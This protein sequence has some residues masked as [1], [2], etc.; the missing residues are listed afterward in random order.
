MR[1][2]V[3]IQTCFW[4]SSIGRVV[5]KQINNEVNK[6]NDAKNK[7]ENK[8]SSAVNNFG[9][10]TCMLYFMQTVFVL[11]SQPKKEKDKNSYSIGHKLF[12]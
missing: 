9:D 4:L 5:L 7:I 12:K 11:D 10:A 8:V 2:K 3:Q 1:K 6:K